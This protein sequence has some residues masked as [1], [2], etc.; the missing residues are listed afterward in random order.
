MNE[1]T[2]RPNSEDQHFGTSPQD[3][4]P[5]ADLRSCCYTNDVWYH[6]ASEPDDTSKQHDYLHYET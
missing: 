1:L 3:S 2:Y 6:A 5:G 4:L